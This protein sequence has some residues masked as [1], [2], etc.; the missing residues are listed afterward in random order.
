[1][2]S[3]QEMLAPCRH[4]RVE[5]I[6]NGNGDELGR[7]CRLCVNLLSGVAQCF[8]CGRDEADIRIRVGDRFYCDDEC[9]KTG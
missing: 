9:K 1:M 6:R 3:L 2:K 8:G 4:P 7:M 5:V